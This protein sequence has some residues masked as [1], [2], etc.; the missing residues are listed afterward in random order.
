MQLTVDP[1]ATKQRKANLRKMKVR[2]ASW[3]IA[4]VRIHISRWFGGSGWNPGL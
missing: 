1:Q 2:V 3:S 4:V